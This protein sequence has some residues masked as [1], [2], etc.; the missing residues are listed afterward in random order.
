MSARGCAHGAVDERMGEVPN[1]KRPAVASGA[2]GPSDARLEQDPGGDDGPR[3]LVLEHGPY[4]VSGGV[5]LT[6]RWPALSRHGEP[7][8]WEPVDVPDADFDVPG[9][10]DLCRCGASKS[11]PFCDGSETDVA[12]DGTLTADRR[13]EGSRRRAF[14][15]PGIA[16][17]DNPRL[18]SHA[19]FCENRFA[20]VWEMVEDSGDPEVRDKIARMVSMC[21]SGRLAWSPEEGGEPVEQ[22]REPSIATV[23]DGPLWVRGGI[24]AQAPDGFVYEL[25]NRQTLCRCGQSKNKPFCDG[26]HANVGFEAPA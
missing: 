23:T 21:P 17:T 5:K 7:I 10:Y 3:I 14:T 19:G 13:P 11:K 18:C 22:E 20:S 24:P 16:V 25:R 6:R 9:T 1:S 26:S 4:R 2:P 15:G 12:F 8:D